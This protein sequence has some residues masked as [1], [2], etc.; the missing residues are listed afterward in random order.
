[1]SSDFIAEI[2]RL[3][4]T[5][6]E[7]DR[8]N[9]TG[10]E[11][12]YGEDQLSQAIRQELRS[13]SSQGFEVKDLGERRLKGLENPEYIY[14]MYPHSLASRLDVQRQLEQK[15]AQQAAPGVGQKMPGSQLTIDTENVWDLWNVSLRLE[16][17]CSTLENPDSHELKPPETALLERMKNRGGEITDRFLINFVEHQISRIEVSGSLLYIRGR[18]SFFLV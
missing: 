18:F 1:V 13:L 3:L 5:H 16:M 2:Q 10:S 15:S 17:L 14:L 9:S 12:Q 8:S 4:E 6:I 11:E 7:G